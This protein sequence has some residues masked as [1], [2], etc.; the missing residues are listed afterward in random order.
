MASINKSEYNNNNNNITMT[1]KRVL[2]MCMRNARDEEIQR[3]RKE[4]IM[5]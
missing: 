5:H 4:Q 1:K 3:K 2:Q